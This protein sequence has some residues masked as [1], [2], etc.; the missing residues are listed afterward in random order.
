[1]KSDIACRAW[2]VDGPQFSFTFVLDN[3]S[4]SASALIVPRVL[5][6]LGAFVTFQVVD[7]AGAAVYETNPPKFTPKL[8]PQSR[9]AYLSIDP[10]YGYA[11][12]FVDPELSLPAG[13]YQ[14]KI[15]YSNLYFRGFAEH[16]LG[17]QRCSTTLAYH[18]R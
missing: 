14:V 15:A 9:D 1:M 12:T 10:G 18:K 16:Q 5:H 8:D 13:A 7:A 2:V 11:T 4:G 3:P 17:E 6:P